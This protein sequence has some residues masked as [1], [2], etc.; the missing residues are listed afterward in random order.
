[1]DPVRV[2]ALH[3]LRAGGLGAVRKVAAR[4]ASPSVP[5]A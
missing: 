1:M 2:L 5:S 3:L 4:T